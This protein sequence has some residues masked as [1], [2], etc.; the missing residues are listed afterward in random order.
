MPFEALVRQKVSVKSVNCMGLMFKNPFGL[1]VGFDKDGEC[2]DVL[3]AMGFGSI[4]IGIVMPC[5]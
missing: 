3:G 2:I 5:P 4:E 1:A